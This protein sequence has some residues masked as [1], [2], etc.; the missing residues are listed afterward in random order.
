MA[1]GVA[2]V[3]IEEGGPVQIMVVA[4]AQV[5][6][7]RKRLILIMGAVLEERGIVLIMAVNAAQDR[8][9][10]PIM[11][12]AALAL[13]ERGSVVIT[14]SVTPALILSMN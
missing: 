3:P 11:V 2:Q 6:T 4:L 10:L 7:E 12:M 13:K 1:V 8:G 5:P 14:I 9:L